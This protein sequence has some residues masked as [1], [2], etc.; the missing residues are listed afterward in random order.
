M[1][2]LD[3]IRILHKSNLEPN[4]KVY[5]LNSNLIT[6]IGRKSDPKSKRNKSQVV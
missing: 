4:K 1:K 2:G 3:S 5:Y 6:A